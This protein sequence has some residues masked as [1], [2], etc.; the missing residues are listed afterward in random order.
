[1]A[2]DATVLLRGLRVGRDRPGADVGPFACLRPGTRIGAGAHIG[3]YVE[4]KN[5]TVGEAPRSR[6]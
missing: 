5:A 6:T 3:A 4:L 2:P 1:M